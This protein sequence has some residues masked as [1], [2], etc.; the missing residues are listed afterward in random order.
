MRLA[1]H[2]G[3]IGDKRNVYMLLVRKAE[4]KRP[5]RSSRLWWVDNIKV[6]LL[7]IEWGDVA[8]IDLAADRSRWRDLV[9]AV[10]NFRFPQN[11]G[12][13]ASGNTT[14]VLSSSA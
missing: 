4:R 12:K 1:G 11:A 8:W 3:R 2:V 5:L 10:M 14:G 9:N 7:E 13:L 6:D